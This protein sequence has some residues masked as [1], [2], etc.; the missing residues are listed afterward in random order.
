MIN[1]ITVTYLKDSR[2]ILEYILNNRKIKINALV[3]RSGVTFSKREGDG[4]TPLGRFFFG[5]I[6]GTHSK[7]GVCIDNYVEINKNLY[8]VDDINSKFYNRLVDITKINKDWKSAEHLIDYPK[9]YEYLI[10]IKVNPY[11]T[12]NKGSAIFL[13]CTNNKFT[14]GCISIDKKYLLDILKNINN[15]TI[16]EITE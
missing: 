3:G 4:K 12:P 6:L 8:W 15:K 14:Q 5:K 16:I 11:N 9:E 10:E 2:A 1:K 7:K 13:H